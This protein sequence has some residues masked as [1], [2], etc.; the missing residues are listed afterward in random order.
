MKTGTFSKNWLRSKVCSISWWLASITIIVLL[1][2]SCRSTKQTSASSVADRLEWNRKVSASLATIPM[3]L[4]EL[5]IP[6][7]SL[8]NLPQ[9]AVYTHKSG[10]ATASIALKGDTVLVYAQ[11]DSLQALVFE[12]AEQLHQARDELEQVDKQTEP[13]IIPFLVK[14]KGCLTG[15]LIGFI[16]ATIIQKIKKWQERKATL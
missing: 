5:T 7:D 3:S 12:L 4:A 1:A 8:R 13:V 9:G 10:Q 15:I 6:I 11:C 14:L 2:A 16:V